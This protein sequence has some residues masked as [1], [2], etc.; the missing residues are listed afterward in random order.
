[1]RQNSQN[2]SSNR[3]I[4]KI[5]GKS[6]KKRSKKTSRKTRPTRPPKMPKMTPN[7]HSRAPRDPPGTQ[8]TSI[9]GVPEGG[10]NLDQKTEAQ[11]TIFF[12]RLGRVWPPPGKPKTRHRQG[13]WLAATLQPC[14][15]GTPRPEK[16]RWRCGGA[17][18]FV[19]FGPLEIPTPSNSIK[20]AVEI[21]PASE[22]LAERTVRSA[23]TIVW[24]LVCHAAGSLWRGAADF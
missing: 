1:M 13:R 17:T 24:H 7:R 18:I 14:G 3:R 9:L 19:I 10:R 4:A 2:R 8:E 16:R 11:K 21:Q 22:M 20:D 6:S 5:D 23:K 15:F 12:P